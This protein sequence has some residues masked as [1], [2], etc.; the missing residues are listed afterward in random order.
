MKT[1]LSSCYIFVER[2]YETGTLEYSKKSKVLLNFNCNV[3][4]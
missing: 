2:K 3:I 4:Q 1:K